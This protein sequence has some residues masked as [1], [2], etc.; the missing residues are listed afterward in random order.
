MDDFVREG[1]AAWWAPALAFAAGVVSFASPCVLPVVP[2]YVTF[3]SGSDDVEEALPVRRRLLPMLLFVLGFAAVF[4]AFGAASGSLRQVLRSETAL[5]I[6][7]VVVLGFG[8]FMLLY[9]L[10]LGR[11]GL[12]A[13]RRPFL[14]RVKPGP[15]GAFPLGMAFATGWTPCIGPVLAGILV[16][17]ANEGAVQGAFLLFVYSLGLGLP[18]VVV[19]LGVSRLVRTLGFLKRNYHWVAGVSGV[20]MSAIGLLLI[21]GLWSR[22]L[23]KV[24]VWVTNF[25]PPI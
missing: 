23:V 25:T 7:G 2:G 10:R 1:L 4:T 18:F 13:E 11:P 6:A 21:T 5:R 17:A 22:L 9:A 14:A 15:A 24:Q 16:I 3:V 19:G 20:L 8:L 12:Y